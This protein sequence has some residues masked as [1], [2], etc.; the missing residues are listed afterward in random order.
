MIL[1]SCSGNSESSTSD[2]V[3]KAKFREKAERICEDIDSSK[4]AFL[5]AAAGDISVEDFDTSLA[6]AE[7]ELDRIISKLE[8]I[9][10][11]EEFE[12]VWETILDDFSAVRDILVNAST[13]KS[14]VALYTDELAQAT[15]PADIEKLQDQLDDA[16]EKLSDIAEDLEM[17]RDAINKNAEKLKIGECEI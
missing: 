9:N 15:E 11:P 3:S 1:S 13:A 17:R 6:E 16:Q 5:E 2:K 4:F 12:D 8:D 10:V 14:D 7:D